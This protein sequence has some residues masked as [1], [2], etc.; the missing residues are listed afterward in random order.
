MLKE[1]RA[2]SGFSVNDI[3]KANGSTGRWKAGVGLDVGD[4]IGEG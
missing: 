2:F 3:P 4:K 1:S